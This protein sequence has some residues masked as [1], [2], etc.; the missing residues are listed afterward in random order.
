MK[1]ILF[2]L[3]LFTGPVMAQTVVYGNNPAA[4]SYLKM[5]DSTRIYYEVYGSGKPLVLLH[6]GLYGD[7]SEYEKLIP[8][9]SKHFKVIAI[10]TRGHAKSEIGQ[11]QY[12]Y[13][14]MA[15]DAYTVIHHLTTDSVLL[16]GFSDGAV[17][18]MDITINHPEMVKKLVFAG[19]NISS[20][21][22]RPDVMNDLKNLSG[23]S[24]EKGDPEFVRERK[25]LMPQ[26]NR[27]GEFVE[28]LKNAWVN[29]VGF[30]DAQLK[31]IK[32]PV[33]IA[34]GD[35]DRY[36]SIESFL[37][38]YKRLA[39]AQLAIIPNSDHIIFYRQPVVMEQLVI[40]F[41]AH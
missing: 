5:T 31:S 11:Q 10:E 18:A 16:V 36:N 38:L 14:L 4:G 2:I 22:Y 29:Q 7:I 6:G 15:A 32:C 25:K 28:K 3:L 20:G 26:P 30:T 33:L 8:A 24:I 23:E 9:L 35:R 40:S 12:T 37:S 41:V 21:A 39:V 17:I 19:G 27:W 13:S 1:K 34:A